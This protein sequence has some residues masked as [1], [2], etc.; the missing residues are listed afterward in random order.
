MRGNY[1]IAVPGRTSVF[2]EGVGWDLENECGKQQ[3]R[4]SAPLFVFVGFGL[5]P[6]EAEG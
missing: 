4:L 3:R 5:K 6:K 1:H 2:G